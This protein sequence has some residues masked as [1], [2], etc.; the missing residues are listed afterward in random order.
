M[1]GPKKDE[2]ELFDDEPE[3]IWDQQDW[4]DYYGVDNQKDLEDAMDDDVWD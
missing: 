3:E 1:K 2:V 4:Y